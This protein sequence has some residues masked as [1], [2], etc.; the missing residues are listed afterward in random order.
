MYDILLL[1]TNDNRF[2]VKKEYNYKNHTI[3]KNYKTNG[4]DVPRILWWYT[5]PFKPKFLPAVI[6]H[7]YYCELKQYE[8]ADDLFEDMLLKIELSFKTKA[9][10][11][12]VRAYSVYRRY[13]N[14]LFS[15]LPF[16]SKFP[17]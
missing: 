3:P 7:D 9:I 13:R 12:S 8:L 2:I 4:A 6:V 1:P 5:P 10:V 17:I 14:L 16:L 15:K 11:K